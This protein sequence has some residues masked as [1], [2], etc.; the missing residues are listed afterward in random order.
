[1]YKAAAYMQSE[2]IFDMVKWEKFLFLSC[3]RFQEKQINQCSSELTKE[4]EFHRFVCFFSV[5]KFEFLTN[6]KSMTTDTIWTNLDR[7]SELKLLC[8]ISAKFFRY[9]TICS[10]DTMA[11]S[12]VRNIARALL[13]TANLSN[14]LK[15]FE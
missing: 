15:D 9:W 3:H 10:N 5:E 7:C 4:I 14:T 8:I 6:I 12:I 11:T 2:M 13:F 1:M